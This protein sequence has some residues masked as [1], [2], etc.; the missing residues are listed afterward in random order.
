MTPVTARKLLLL[1]LLLSP[2]SVAPAAAANPDDGPWRIT[3][4]RME[5]SADGQVVTASGAVELTPAEGGADTS[6]RAEKVIYDR[7]TAVLE[8]RGKVEVRDRH[9]K[10]FADTATINLKT[11]AI[12]L[13]NGRLYYHP[14][15]LYLSADE[16][17]RSGPDTW[18]FRKLTLST[19]E[20]GTDRKPD[21]AFGAGR[22]RI[23]VD[24]YA[25]LTN[26]TFRVRD[27]PVLYL[28]WL[29]FPAK[30]RRQ[31]GFLFPQLS[32]SSR[33]GFGLVT[34]FFVN[35]SPS[36]D[37]TLSPGY[38]EKRGSSFG[39]EARYRVSRNGAGLAA[40]SFLHDRTEER[41]IGDDD[42]YRSD[43]WLRDRHDRYWVRGKIDQGLAAGTAVS[44]DFDL[45]GDPDFILEYRDAVDGF[46]QGQ[47]QSLAMFNR[48]YQDPGLDQRENI[49][50]LTAVH[51]Y[52]FSGLQAVMVDDLREAD[53]PGT[54]VQTLPRFAADLRLPLPGM[55]ATL[56]L[57]SG[58]VNYY[59]RQGLGYQRFTLAPAVVAGLPVG[60]F[61]GKVRVSSLNHLYLVRTHGDG[62]DESDTEERSAV[63]VSANMASTWSRDFFN[64]RL[65]HSLRPNLVYTYV[66]PGT[67]GDVPWIDADDRLTFT[68]NITWELNNY[69]RTRH[70]LEN[71][72]NEERL[73]ARL[74]LSQAYDIH[75]ER[76]APDPD[77]PRRPF[78][79]LDLD[80]ELYPSD[81]F[82]FRYQSA[83][84]LYGDHVTRSAV[85]GRYSRGENRVSLNYNYS[86][87]TARDL[88][89]SIEIKPLDRISLAYETSQSLLYDHK[90]RESAAI[91][92]TPGC[93]G[94]T[95]EASQDT[96]DRKVMMVLTLS[97]LGRGV[98]WG[99]N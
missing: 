17:R 29:V 92:Y 54:A 94:L 32:S 1:A 99:A 56:A 7:R 66:D 48:G 97:G 79:D 85:E 49:F 59:R 73:A 84:N 34:P 33:D 25:F 75:E 37:L 27:I 24:G 15:H 40:A 30:T 70:R 67:Q 82:Y 71:G 10:L 6:I 16:I 43:G 76:R 83:L 18:H 80:L 13:G 74:K 96:D 36:V 72:E 61:E 23:T 60:F 91:T 47:S 90:T 35:I 22:G 62:P 28:P 21:W 52:G 44:V 69:F 46:K 8:A 26:V 86:R 51:A 12:T 31:S 77:R 87:G 19:C 38:Y 63:A 45:A 2:F 89:A 11:E 57:E 93:W 20:I 3:A 88:T 98:R 68:N 41:G 95:I 9:D 53:A 58:Y 65:Q 55:P 39:F 14:N 5:S 4:D 42:D 78:G 64:H 81:R 50:A